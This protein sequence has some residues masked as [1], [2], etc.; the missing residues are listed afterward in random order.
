M[1]NPLQTPLVSV[2]MPAYNAEK[3]IAEAIESII[4][5][6][7]TNWELLIADDG[8]T[9]KTP[10]IISEYEKKES[11]IKTYHNFENIGYLKTC[12]KLF[13]LCKG[14]FI[15]FQDADDWSMKD[16]FEKQIKV[17]MNNDEI[18]LCGTWFNIIDHKGKTIRS[19]KN[20]TTHNEIIDTFMQRNPI[21]PAS[22]MIKRIVYDTIGG[23]RSYFDDKAYQDY[24]WVWLI[25]E[26]YSCVNLPEH[27]YFYRQHSSSISKTIEPQRLISKTIVINL[28]KQRKEFGKDDLQKKNINKLDAL[29]NKLYN[30]LISEPSKVYREYAGMYAYNNMYK[31]AVIASFHSLLKDPFMLLNYKY[32]IVCLFSLIKTNLKNIF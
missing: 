5:Q 10:K 20:P 2:I 19:S 11:R 15:T 30:Q 22:I 31:E 12:N 16:R 8:S 25:A 7:Y 27:L 21:L 23:Y 18:G 24:D 28:A 4:S 17:F 29:F 26:N 6:K 32:F 3:Y 14:D 13:K 1:D 9:D